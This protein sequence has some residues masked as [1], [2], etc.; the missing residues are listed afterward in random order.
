MHDD[1]ITLISMRRVKDGRG[2]PRADEEVKRT[3]YCQVQDVKR[4][5]YYSAQQAG[6]RPDY[7]VMIHPVEYQGESIAEYHG[8]R[9]A[10]YRT[11]RS[12][13]DVLEMQIQREGGV[14]Q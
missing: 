5:E 3:V 1:V 8:V 14:A 9:Y 13:A 12:A 11:Y 7:T 6:F 4:S 10:I 2:V